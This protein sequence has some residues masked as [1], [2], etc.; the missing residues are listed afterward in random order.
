MTYQLLAN[1]ALCPINR[2]RVVALITCIHPECPYLDYSEPR[3]YGGRWWHKHP[4]VINTPWSGR[5]VQL[6]LFE[7]LP[8]LETGS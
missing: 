4:T 7:T 6:E 8:L 3:G 1:T 2:T 5:P